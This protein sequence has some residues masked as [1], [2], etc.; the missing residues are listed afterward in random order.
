MLPPF[1]FLVFFLFS[2]GGRGRVKPL[3]NVFF[4]FLLFGFYCSKTLRLFWHLESESSFSL[5]ATSRPLVFSVK[6]RCCYSKE[7]EMTLV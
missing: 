4:Y 7:R 3:K 2:G 1:L 6:R 5:V